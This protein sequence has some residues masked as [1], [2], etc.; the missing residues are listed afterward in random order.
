MNKQQREAWLAKL[1][2][3]AHGLL[4]ELLAWAS[5]LQQ[6]PGYT[7]QV[8]TE[9]IASFVVEAIRRFEDDVEPCD[10]ALEQ[11]SREMVLSIRRKVCRE[12]PD[13]VTQRFHEATRQQVAEAKARIS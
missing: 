4:H 5:E 9:A 7:L 11:V 1:E 6:P 10:D 12:L 2:E 8:A 3:D 13:K